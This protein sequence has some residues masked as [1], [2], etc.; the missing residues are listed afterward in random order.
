[1]CREVLDLLGRCDLHP[2]FNS[3]LTSLHQT[4]S[5][6]NSTIHL[7]AF[8]DVHGLPPRT[9]QVSQILQQHDTLE[10]V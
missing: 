8:H 9:A 5:H 4:S 6:C 2:L 7:S 10:S 1:M 3:P